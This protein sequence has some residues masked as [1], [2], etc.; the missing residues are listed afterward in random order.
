MPITTA[1]PVADCALFKLPPELRN[2]IYEYGVAID[3]DEGVGTWP[4]ETPGD[5]KITREN[6][7]P[8]PALLTT[9]KTDR[10]EAIEV[11]YN[12]HS[13]RLVMD[14]FDSTP[15]VL[16]KR[17]QISLSTQYDLKVQEEP[18]WVESPDQRSWANLKIWLERVH[19][20][21]LCDAFCEMWEE[22]RYGEADVLYRLPRMAEKLRDKPWAEVE[23]LVNNF[24]GARSKG[25]RWSG[26]GIDS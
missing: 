14:S 24:R 17:K 3:P 16:G 6:G 22:F 10:R 2:R 25:S 19:Q 1:H 21:V 7:I 15:A 20:E 13:V 18:V 4:E 12:L 8:E 26:M 9:C 23:K 11:Y 5:I